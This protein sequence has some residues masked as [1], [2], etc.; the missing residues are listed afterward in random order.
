M[1]FYN[2]TH[3]KLMGY[4][5]WL[6]GFTGA[7]RFYY[8]RPLTG[9]IW[10]FTFGLFGIGW[11]IDLF[12]IPSMDAQMDYQYKRGRID[13][14][15]AWILLT[16]LGVFG[17]HRLYLG[18]WLSGLFMLVVTLSLLASSLVLPFLSLLV[19]GVY[20]VLIYDFWTLN[21]RINLIN[22]QN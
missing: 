4:V 7:H 10:F 6:F 16:F 21:Q 22:R 11:L 20:I 5:L 15:L 8:A 3:S 17:L 1:R 19:L 2:D 18:E 12:L 13:Y 14:S 9:T